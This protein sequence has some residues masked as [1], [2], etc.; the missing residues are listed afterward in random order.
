MLLLNLCSNVDKSFKDELSGTDCLT[1]YAVE[2]RYPDDWYE[3]TLEETKQAYETA[4]KV[5]DF[6]LKKLNINY[7]ND[8]NTSN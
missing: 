1:D 7:I 4:L 5:K 3:P 8:T 6:V 2:I